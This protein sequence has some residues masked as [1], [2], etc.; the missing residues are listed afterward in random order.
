MCVSCKQKADEYSE[1]PVVHLADYWVVVAS[2]VV[3]RVGVD[4]KK[5]TRHLP[6]R[7]RLKKTQ[8]LT[9]SLEG[10]VDIFSTILFSVVR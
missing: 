7:R 9:N 8:K 10:V 6:L 1:H 3:L 4:S 5:V 2:V